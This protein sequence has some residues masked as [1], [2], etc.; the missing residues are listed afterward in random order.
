MLPT[1][2]FCLATEPE[3]LDSNLEPKSSF[4]SYMLLSMVFCPSDEMGTNAL[5]D[6][7]VLSY[8]KIEKKMKPEKLENLRKMMQIFEVFYFGSNFLL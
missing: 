2:I 8:F 7:K 6:H 4:L 1:M 5:P 3:T